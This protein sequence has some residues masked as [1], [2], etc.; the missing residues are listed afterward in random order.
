MKINSNIENS[1]T[2]DYIVAEV[3]GDTYDD[4]GILK[5]KCY[6]WLFRVW[7]RLNLSIIRT[8]RRVILPIAAGTKTMWLPP[9]YEDLIFLGYH[10]DCGNA[11]PIAV[12]RN[13]AP[14]IGV[15]NNNVC[16]TCGETDLCSLDM[17][18]TEETVMVGGQPYQKTTSRIIQPDGSYCEEVTEPVVDYNAAQPAVDATAGITINAVPANG[19]NIEVLVNDPDLGGISL[20]SYIKGSG[21]TTIP[22]LAASIAAA[23]ASN[24]NAYGVIAINDFI[25]ITART[26]LG[27]SINGNNLSVTA[28]ITAARNA[29]AFFGFPSPVSTGTVFTTTVVDPNLGTITLA[30]YTQ[31]AGDTTPAIFNANFMASLNANTHNYTTTLYLT[32]GFYLVAPTGYGSS[33]N[34]N[35]AT[36]KQGSSSQLANFLNGVDATG[37]I[38]NTLTQFIGGAAQMI[39]VIMQTSRRLVCKLPDTC[40][41]CVPSTPGNISM[42]AGCGCVAAICSCC[43]NDMLPYSVL[44]AN[45]HYNL[46]EQEGF[47]QFSPNSCLTSAILSYVSRGVCIQGVY[48]FPLASMETL[49]SGT[50]YRSIE[51]KKG[52]PANEK[53]RARRA[54]SAE[55]T[56]LLKNFTRLNYQEWMDMLDVVPRLPTL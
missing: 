15:E 23:L 18:L 52:V 8:K 20:G 19:Y 51:K 42:L 24:S 46:F 14:Q 10:D 49:I 32:T 33:I 3:L 1:I 41:N 56:E 7:T 48:Y 28:N 22:I 13:L 31:Q 36:I 16:V 34:G 4:A 43:T 50:Y 38:P 53:D 11:L 55:T 40:D 2:A 45:T 6:R 54:Y 9:D 25:K 21:D 47:I 12:N 44:P 29:Q 17:E 26:G 27:S 37:I 39:P 30:V 35:N 5:E